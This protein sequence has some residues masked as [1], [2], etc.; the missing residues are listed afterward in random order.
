MSLERE[1]GGNHKKLTICKT[2]HNL[3][4]FVN[5]NYKNKNPKMYQKKPLKKIY[6]LLK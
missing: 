3:T 4:N 1:S 2:A 6:A 5:N